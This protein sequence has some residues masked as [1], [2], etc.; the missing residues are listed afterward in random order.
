MLA[1]EIKQDMI[2]EEVIN[3]LTNICYKLLPLNKV[4]IIHN[5]HGIFINNGLIAITLIAQDNSDQ[6]IF[7]SIKAA[8]KYHDDFSK[9]YHENEEIGLLIFV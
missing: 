5:E 7:L 3:D 9:Y 1:Q 6:S 4:H 2:Q 8:Q